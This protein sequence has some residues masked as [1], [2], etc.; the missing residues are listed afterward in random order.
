MMSRSDLFV[1]LMF[2]SEPPVSTAN[3]RQLSSVNYPKPAEQWGIPCVMGC[4]MLPVMRSGLFCDL[5]T[6]VCVSMFQ[7][8][9]PMNSVSSTEDIKPPLGLNG[10]MK[11]PAQPSGTSLSLS[12][13]ICTICGDRSSG[14]WAF[15]LI[16]GSLVQ[17]L[18]CSRLALQYFIWV[19]AWPRT[20]G[21]FNL[22]F[23]EELWGKGTN[24]NIKTR[25]L[26]NK[27]ESR[28]GQHLAP[29]FWPLKGFDHTE[30]SR[31]H[32]RIVPHTV[33]GLHTAAVNPQ[34]GTRTLNVDQGKN[35][36]EAALIHE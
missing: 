1:L 3:Y 34:G 13:H 32:Y 2:L 27:K 25:L 8:N 26:R 28:A 31:D 12:K 11:V 4:M 22:S 20:S 21:N 17:D 30:T 18:F 35:V 7:L 29:Q 23:W 9:S 16:I 19:L 10:V 15:K 5:S 24:N 6:C 14:E 33:S 36:K